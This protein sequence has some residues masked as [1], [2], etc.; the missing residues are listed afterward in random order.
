VP[1]VSPL[2]HP[3]CCGTFFMVHDMAFVRDSC[4]IMLFLSVF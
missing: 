4:M 2:G 3:V 1:L